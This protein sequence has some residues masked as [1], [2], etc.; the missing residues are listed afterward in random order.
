VHKEIII[1]GDASE[2][3]DNAY[4][5]LIDGGCEPVVEWP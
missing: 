3:M 1:A 2:T 4:Y 5:R